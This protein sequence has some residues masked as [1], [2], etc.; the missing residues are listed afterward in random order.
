MVKEERALVKSHEKI[1]SKIRKLLQEGK[2]AAFLTI[3]DP[4]VYSTYRRA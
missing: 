3:G 2:Q 1:Y 4:A